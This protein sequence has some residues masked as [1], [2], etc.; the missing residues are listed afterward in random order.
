MG[1]RIRQLTV[2]LKSDRSNRKNVLEEVIPVAETQY[3]GGCNGPGAK[4]LSKN[5]NSPRK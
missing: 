1:K 2:I 5:P 4:Q 3:P